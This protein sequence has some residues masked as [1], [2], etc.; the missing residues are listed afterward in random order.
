MGVSPSLW[1]GVS[2]KVLWLLKGVRDRHVS[3]QSSSS[4]TAKIRIFLTA[5]KCRV[6]PAYVKKDTFDLSMDI[7]SVSLKSTLRSGDEKVTDM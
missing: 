6:S 1:L 3:K 4:I 7:W 5:Q 2:K